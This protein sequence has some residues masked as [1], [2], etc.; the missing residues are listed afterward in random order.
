MQQGLWI[1]SGTVNG[2]QPEW[3]RVINTVEVVDVVR[4]RIGG[5]T[6]LFSRNRNYWTSCSMKS[7]EPNQARDPQQPLAAEG[8]ITTAP[9]SKRDPY[10]ALDDLMVV[11]EALCP[12]WPSRDTFKTDGLWLL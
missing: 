7:A 1:S 4:C 2:R 5:N 9:V 10:E 3:R 11:V 12:R 6:S 8:G